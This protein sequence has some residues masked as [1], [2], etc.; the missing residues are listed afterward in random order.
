M[1]PDKMENLFD[2]FVEDCGN[3]PPVNRA[4]E[5]DGGAFGEQ[6][7]RHVDGLKDSG[8]PPCQFGSR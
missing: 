3:H 4:F 5:L 8:R 2:V 6:I 7:I 1:F